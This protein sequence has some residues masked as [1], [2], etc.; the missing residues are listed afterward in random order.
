MDVSIN[1]Y[2]HHPEL[3][4]LISDPSKSHF[5]SFDAHATIGQRPE[6]EW[7][8]EL[9]S[10]KPERDLSRKQ[11]LAGKTDA[12]LWVFAY[13][14]L[15]WDPALQFSEVRRVHVRDYA[16]HFIL[17]DIYGGRGTREAPGLMAAL[18]RGG[19]CDGLAFRIAKEDIESETEILWRREMVGEG[20][21]P[22]FVTTTIADQPVDALTF[23]ADLEAESI[24]ADVTRQEQIQYLSSGEGFIG[25]SLEYLEN[26][27]R[28]FEALG[29]VDHECTTLLADVHARCK[30]RDSKTAGANA[31]SQGTT[32]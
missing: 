28:Q 22:T 14:S 5:R 15:M 10:T 8:I 7:V 19:G 6:L 11:T 13:G 32:D 23:V 12:D 27:V 4:E 20:Y 9:L 21:I 2:S 31:S 1:P 16:R 18:S 30:L 29:I 26:I 3:K 25:T 24:C 17:K